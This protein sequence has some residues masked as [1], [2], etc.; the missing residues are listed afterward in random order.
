MDYWTMVTNGRKCKRQN[1][2]H[3][4]TICN[5]FLFNLDHMDHS[6][7]IRE[8]YEYYPSRKEEKE[9]VV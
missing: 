6:G 8:I 4:T 2:L 9:E 3:T 5:V 7:M 1:M